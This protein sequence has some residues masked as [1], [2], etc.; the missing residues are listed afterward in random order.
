M[1]TGPDFERMTVEDTVLWLEEQGIPNE[2]CD[3]FAGTVCL[4]FY[5]VV[6]SL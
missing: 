4:L 5:L 1:A 2:F 3:A 6:V